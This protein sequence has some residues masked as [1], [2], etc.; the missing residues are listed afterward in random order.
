MPTIEELVQK[1]DTLSNQ[2][3]SSDVF[4]TS[5]DELKAMVEKR[6]DDVK[7]ELKSHYETAM[8]AASEEFAEKLR[9]SMVEMG[10][11]FTTSGETGEDLPDEKTYGKSF[12]EFLTK[13]KYTPES[14]KVLGE[15]TGSAGGYLVPT[16]WS[17]RIL[18]RAIEKGL[19]RTFGPSLIDM[20]TPKFEVPTITSTSNSS[21]FYGGI[22]TYWGS[23][24]TDLEAGITQPTFG[25]V[26]LDAGKLYG[27]AESSEDLA[28][29][30][31][32][33]IGPLLQQL[34]GDAIA[35]EED[36]AFING[37]G[38]G[39]PLGV[40]NAP[41]RV[42]VS[43]ATATQINTIDIVN[44][45]SRFSGS[46]DNA[47]WLANQTVLP[48]LYTLQDAGGNYILFPGMSGNIAGRSPGSIFGIP[49]VI[50]EKAQAL[51]TSGDLILGDWSN[52]LIG[53][54][55]G[56]RIEESKDFKFGTDKRCWKIVKRVDGK[57]WLNSAITPRNGG[58]TLSPFVL[59]S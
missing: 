24:T 40:V 7:V 19:V 54:L 18:K 9:L 38:V 43:R 14:L 22:M 8:K 27:Y 6:N 5:L 57:P 2:R 13:V 32:I 1:I 39:K 47:V 53:D 34:F 4:K 58:S 51:G 35:F 28:Q 11:T 56:L 49:L 48:Y 29:D 55:R 30:A 15:N 26:N 3:V 21:N 36:Y 42:T 20:P 16:T 44:M 23:E 45:L 37:N 41:C 33:A 31:I 12:G 52:Y 50:S 17:K 59:I 10:K 25:Q 46:M